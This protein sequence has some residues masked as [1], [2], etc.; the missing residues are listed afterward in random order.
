M[1]K[2]TLIIITCILFI[3]SSCNKEEV[4]QPSTNVNNNVTSAEA[5]YYENSG[6][7][8]KTTD[9]GVTWT[10]QNSD[11]RGTGLNISFIN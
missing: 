7:F 4:I 3:F 6:Y 2:K 11:D 1:I 9:S 10:A 8:Y 5:G